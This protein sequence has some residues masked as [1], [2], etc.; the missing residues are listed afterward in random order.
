[1]IGKI[2]N[3]MK[4]RKLS[5][6]GLFL[7]IP[8]SLIGGILSIKILTIVGIGLLIVFIVISFLFWKCPHCNERL[9]MRFNSNEDI[10]D[11]YICPYCNK[12]F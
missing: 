7:S 8:T 10:D 2:K 12:K 11:I 3:I 5:L 4:L 6:L 1:M 9:P